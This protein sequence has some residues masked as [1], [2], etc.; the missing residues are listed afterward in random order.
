MNTVEDGTWFISPIVKQPQS[1]KRQ[2]LL[3]HHIHIAIQRSQLDIEIHHIGSDAVAVILQIQII[4][5]GDGVFVGYLIFKIDDG[6][7]IRIETK[8]KFVGLFLICI[9]VGHGKVVALTWQ[10]DR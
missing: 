3:H 6:D 9:G 1:G 5:E 8:A 4:R 7:I 10:H 2:I